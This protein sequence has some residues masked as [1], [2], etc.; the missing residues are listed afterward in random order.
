[1]KKLKK[2][3][4]YTLSLSVIF[5]VL[6]IA[7]FFS[8]K[9]VITNTFSAKNLSTILYEPKWKSAE[10]M[11]PE[12]V[13]EKDPTVANN[14]DVSAYVFL[15]VTV[16]YYK[17]NVYV[18]DKDG[19]AIGGAGSGNIAAANVVPM[20]RFI[21]GATTGES[22]NYNDLNAEAILT[23][24][25]QPVNEGWVLLE[26]YPK[27]EPYTTTIG[28]TADAGNVKYIYA[29]TGGDAENMKPLKVGEATPPLFNK[30]KL[31]NIRDNDVYSLEKT[32]ADIPLAVQVTNRSIQAS[33]STEN[34]EEVWELL[35]E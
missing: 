27:L 14:G 25:S 33:L 29:Y 13:V 6:A 9:D 26:G 3:I 31:I 24:L 20:F 17:G 22:D 16:P 1:M 34:K 11:T 28:G 5:A 21:T 30:V 32:F 10:N 12:E 18:E 35:D 2:R 8:A 19:K 15:E 4:I 23:S 7:A